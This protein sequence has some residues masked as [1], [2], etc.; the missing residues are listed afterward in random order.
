MND[1]QRTFNCKDEELPVIGNYVAF[2]VNRDIAD[3]TA[4]SPVFT[5]E[6]VTDFRVK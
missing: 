6:Y 1:P 4:F 3:F 5:P 2:S